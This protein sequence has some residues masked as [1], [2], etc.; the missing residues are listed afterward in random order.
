MDLERMESDSGDEPSQAESLLPLVYEELRRLAAA[1]LVHDQAMTI[2]PTALVHE[3]FLKLSR[4]RTSRWRDET[5]FRAVASIAMRRVLADHVKSRR[6]LKRGGG[7]IGLSLHEDIAGVHCPEVGV[8]DDALTELERLSP[9]IAR[10]VVY[11]FFG[12]LSVFQ[13]ADR[14]G[15]SVSTAEADWR[16][17][18]AWLRRKL[19]GGGNP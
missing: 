7:Q 12:E 13:A 3:A 11:R 5:H 6:R 10:L 19:S 18:K 14:L 1:L 4:E 9:R 8:L 16:F 2:Q 17:A 15:M